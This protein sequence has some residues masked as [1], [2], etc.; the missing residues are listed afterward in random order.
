[1]FIVTGG[2]GFIGSNLVKGLNDRGE[3]DILVVDDLTDGD[4]FLNLV[5]CRF[6]DYLDRDDFRTRIRAGE[7]FGPVAAVFRVRIGVRLGCCLV[8][9]SVA[10][11]VDSHAPACD[12]LTRGTRLF[13]IPVSRER[14]P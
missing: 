7:S 12:H 13:A 11:L 3:E 9:L 5:D 14:D 1:M 8:S 6:A 10:V 4:K 2:A